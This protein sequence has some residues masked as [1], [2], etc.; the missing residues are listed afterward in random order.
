MKVILLTKEGLEHRY[1]FNSLARVLGD[2]LCWV[3]IEESNERLTLYKYWKRVSNKYSYFQIAERTVTRIF[4]KLLKYDQKKKQALVKLLDTECL[5]N[6]RTEIS[7]YYGPINNKDTID[8]I[9]RISPDII[10]VYGT[11]YIGSRLLSLA[12]ITS[13]NMHTGLSPYYRG[14][15]TYF[16]PLYNGDLGMVG[17]TVHECTSQIDGGCIYART[18]TRLDENDDQ[19]TVFARCVKAGAVIYSEVVKMFLEGSVP[20]SEKQNLSLGREYRFRDRTF[21]QDMRM[22]YLVRSGKLRSIIR[23]SCKS[24]TQYPAND[25][26]C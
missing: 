5:Y 26:S 20:P 13:L 1:V 3:F 11:N 7:H 6:Q 17:A 21:M 12:K 9:K 2:N 15:D 14:S 19:F 24:E 10:L 8:R 16:W 22:E 18:V 23:N 4:R 25:L